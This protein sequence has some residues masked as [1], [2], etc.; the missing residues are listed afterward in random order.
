MSPSR[1][2][3]AW[4]ALLVV[5]V[6]NGALRQL[7]LVRGVGE[8]AAHQLSCA[9]GIV[10][11]GAA[12]YLLTRRW[13]ITAPGEAWAVGT[14]WL[15]L[16]TAFETAMGVARGV[17]WRR[18]LADYAVWNGRL[19]PFVLLWILVLPRLVFAL[20]LRWP[21]SARSTGAPPAPTAGA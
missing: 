17:S 19:W 13:R 2:L 12:A 20:E 9:T 5:A 14:L 15:V 16:T 21:R 1:A 4:F 8:L 3:A 10:L 18:I 6:A 11:L 7:V